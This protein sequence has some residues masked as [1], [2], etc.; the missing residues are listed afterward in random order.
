MQIQSLSLA[1]S[2]YFNLSNAEDIAKVRN[3]EKCCSLK[4]FVRVTLQKSGRQG[5][6]SKGL[7]NFVPEMVGMANV[8]FPKMVLK[9]LMLKARL[10]AG[11]QRVPRPGGEAMVLR[12]LKH[13]SLSTLFQDGFRKVECCR[14]GSLLFQ[15]TNGTSNTFSL[16]LD[17][18]MK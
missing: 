17:P 4:V 15:T 5:C 2:I 16:L 7:C 13:L 1:N 11:C 9:H 18:Q 10:Q 8:T 12:V 14:G 3:L 6:G